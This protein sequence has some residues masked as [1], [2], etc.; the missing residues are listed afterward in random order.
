MVLHRGVPSNSCWQTYGELLLGE[1]VSHS[2]HAPASMS[3]LKPYG[4]TGSVK[5]RCF[6]QTVDQKLHS[7][8]KVIFPDGTRKWMT[9]FTANKGELRGY[10]AHHN[11]QHYFSFPLHSHAPSAEASDPMLRDLGRITFM[12]TEGQRFWHE[13]YD[14]HVPLEGRW[15]ELHHFVRFRM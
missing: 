12:L 6:R 14:I 1:D 8:A 4:F 13:T 5:L 9:Q 10:Y 3:D 2:V 11:K 15:E 7:T